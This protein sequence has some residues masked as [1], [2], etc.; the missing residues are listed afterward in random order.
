MKMVRSCVG[1]SHPFWS[2][3]QPPSFCGCRCYPP[4]CRTPRTRSFR[5]RP[6]PRTELSY[7]RFVATGCL[8]GYYR[9]SFSIPT[10]LSLVHN[11][12]PYYM[13]TDTHLKQ[14][15]VGDEP[16]IVHVV[17]SKREPQL[18]ELVPLNAKLRD[19]LDKFCN[20]T[21]HRHPT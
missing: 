20:E 4:R 13:L 16:V 8:S 21:F 12:Y 14:F 15:P 17:D 6:C 3:H 1:Q 2:R 18:R 9:P 19:S 5:P 7:Q 10:T 11:S